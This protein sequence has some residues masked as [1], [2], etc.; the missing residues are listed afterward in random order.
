[1]TQK[2]IIMK[3]TIRYVSAPDIKVKKGDRQYHTPEVMVKNKGCGKK[4]KRNPRENLYPRLFGDL[5]PSQKHEKGRERKIS[6]DILC[7]FSWMLLHF[8][9]LWS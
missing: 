8:W 7:L 6:K 5:C 3:V 4:C 9:R 1:M 2:K